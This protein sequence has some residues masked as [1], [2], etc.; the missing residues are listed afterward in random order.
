MYQ[1]Y[2]VAGSCSTNL[3]TS[4]CSAW[5]GGNDLVTEGHYVMDHS[6]TSIVFTNWHTG[7]PSLHDPSQA[8]GRDCIDIIGNG[9][10]NDRPCSHNN[11]FICEKII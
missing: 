5:T 7:E 10:W 8:P 4:N 6:N 11:K 2:I 3:Y 1:H 9:K